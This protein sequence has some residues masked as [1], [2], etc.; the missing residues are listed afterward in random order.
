MKLHIKIH[1]SVVKIISSHLEYNWEQPYD[2]SNIKNSVGSGFFFDHHGHIL[3]CAHV[4][5]AAKFIYIEI[6]Q[7]SSQRYEA[8]VISIYAAAD[9]AVLQIHGYRNRKTLPLGSCRNVKQGASSTG[10]GF[11]LGQKNL[12]LN[13]GIISGT[14]GYKIQSDT[15]INPGNSGGPLLVKGRVIGINQSGITGTNS[16]TYATPIDIFLARRKEMLPH[17]S[18]QQPT[19]LQMPYFGMLVHGASPELLHLRHC[20]NMSGG[21][22]IARIFPGSIFQHHLQ[23]N[24]ILLQCNG[25]HIDSYMFMNWNFGPFKLIELST[26]FAFVAP[27]QKLKLSVWNGKK[28]I[29]HTIQV[30]LTPLA[31]DNIIPVY[32]PVQYIQFAGLILCNLTRNHVRQQVRE[33]LYRWDALNYYM[34]PAHFNE[35]AILCTHII[36]NSFFDKFDILETGMILHKI[37]DT[38]VTSVHQI[39]SIVQS[40]TKSILLQFSDNIQVAI[41]KSDYQRLA[42][43][44]SDK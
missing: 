8:S 19:L 30:Q 11:P 31:V 43:I 10:I 33:Q 28:K 12:K 7:I 14:E 21:T 23:P 37:N 4:V 2:E 39:K 3:T 9:L 16:I 18:I 25:H 13:E 32:Q 27:Q 17:K 29:N 44:S 36:P 6:P 15:P 40:I 20:P 26:Y 22:I 24:D 34:D 41:S 35:P 38:P 1:D 42:D 5:E